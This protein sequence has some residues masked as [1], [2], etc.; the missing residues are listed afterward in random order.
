MHLKNFTHERAVTT[1]LMDTDFNF[2]LSLNNFTFAVPEKKKLI[3]EHQQWGASE[4][5]METNHKKTQKKQ[6]MF[7]Y[8]RREKPSLKSTSFGLKSTVNW[9]EFTGAPHKTAREEKILIF[10]T[11][12]L[13]GVIKHM[14]WWLLPVH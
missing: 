6:K 4:K 12:L 11:D 14:V 13:T 9:I 2:I 7:Y 1:K 10:G 8:W 3:S 5:T